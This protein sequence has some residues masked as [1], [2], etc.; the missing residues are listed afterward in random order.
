MFHKKEK[1]ETKSENHKKI[2]IQIKKTKKENSILV[3][4]LRGF[5]TQTV[6]GQRIK[7]TTH[8]N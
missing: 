8:F 2:N 4:T 1:N 5:N 6:P 7:C 3:P